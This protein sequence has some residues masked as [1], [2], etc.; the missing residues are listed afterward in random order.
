VSRPNSRD[1]EKDPAAA[2]GQTLKRLREAAGIPTWA[3]AGTRIGYG[4][5]LIR[6]AES[7][8]QVPSEVPFLK[9]L[10]LYQVPD[11]MRP[12]VIDMWKLARKS[13]GPI[14]EFAQKYFEA[15]E[16]AAFLRFWALYLVPGPLQVKEYAEAMYDLP[17]MDPDKAAETVAIRMQ[18]QSIINEPDAA[19]VICVLHEAVL[20]NLM[21]AP[22]VMVKQIDRLLE[23][24]AQPNVTVQIINGKGAYW[25]LPGPFQ[26]ASGPEIVDTLLMLAVEDQTSEDPTLTRKTL[27]LFERIRS[28]AHPLE[29]SR[30]I[31]MEARNHWNSQQQ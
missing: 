6:K 15:A 20:Y 23:A 24:S 8:A 2:L 30:V 11:L 26:I 12:T 10:D 22:A 31:M 3:A 29:E 28:N 25:G 17:G 9:M 14:P 13:K 7:G 21:G 19:Q 5:D 18:R 16:L 27:I 4:E 1:P